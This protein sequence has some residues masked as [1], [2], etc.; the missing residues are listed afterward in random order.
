VAPSAAP[1]DAAASATSSV[2]ASGLPLGD[3]TSGDILNIPEQIGYLKAMGLDYGWGPTSMMQWCLEHI[4]VYTGLPWWASI[5]VLG[6]G[7]RAALFKPSLTAAEHQYKMQELTKT[8]PRYKELTDIMQDPTNPDTQKKLLAFQEMG[9]IRKKHGI[10][11]WR[12]FVPMLTLPVTLGFFRLFQGMAALPVPSLE[13]GGILWFQDLAAADPLYILPILSSSILYFVMKMNAPYMPEA[14]GK[15]MKAIAL[16]MTPMT[17]YFTLNFPAGLQLFFLVVGGLQSFQSWVFFQ[18]WFR[19]MVGLPPVERNPTKP[20]PGRMSYQP[21][22]TIGTT[23]TTVSQGAVGGKIAEVKEGIKAVQDKVDQYTK[24]QEN[25][26]A[27]SSVK[28][29]E[30]KRRNEEQAR[31]YA[32][33]EEQRMRAAEKQRRNQA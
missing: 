14:S 13:T 25:K 22:R 16:V 11:Q 15:M 23:A 9:R 4:Y 33:I 26:K 21:A 10:Q 8:D 3:L 32:R 6:L 17:L 1:S 18:P 12:S 19:R 5:V 28:E 2:D 29:Y 30:E 24:K 31:Y 20:A 27:V 7:I